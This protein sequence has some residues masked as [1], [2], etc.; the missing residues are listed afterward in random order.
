[1]PNLGMYGLYIE[2]STNIGAILGI[3]IISFGI[4]MKDRYREYSTIIVTESA[5]TLSRYR[6][7][8]ICQYRFRML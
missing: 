1:M 4:S 8:I 2:Y 7:T 3:S 5:V 6:M